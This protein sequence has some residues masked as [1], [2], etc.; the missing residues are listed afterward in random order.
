MRAPE[1]FRAARHYDILSDA[2]LT[3]FLV[4]Y[5]I[6][7]LACAGALMLAFRAGV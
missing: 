1:S 7:L 2:E 4:V 5:A 3:A 6:M